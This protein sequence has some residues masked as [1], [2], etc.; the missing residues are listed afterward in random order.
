MEE[1]TPLYSDIR[2]A[3]PSPHRQR[4]ILAFDDTSVEYARLNHSV[5]NKE[6]ATLKVFTRGIIQ[7]LCA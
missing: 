2:L 5:H 4:T 7:Q 6:A 1:S 3:D